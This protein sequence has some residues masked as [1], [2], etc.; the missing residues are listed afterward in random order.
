MAQV[1]EIVE[2]FFENAEAHEQFLRRV[3]ARLVEWAVD[4]RENVPASPTAAEV[5]RQEFAVQVL[6]GAGRATAQAKKLLPALAV[7]ANAAG[8]INPVGRIEATDAQIMST[9]NDALIE[10]H[11]GYVPDAA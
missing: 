2:L 10:L 9:V 1:Y 3:T 4:E 5:A 7:K 11:A 8:L 6:T